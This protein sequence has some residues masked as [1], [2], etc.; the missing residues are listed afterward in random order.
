MVLHPPAGVKARLIAGDVAALLA[1]VAL[2]VLLV[3]VRP[4]E[5]VRPFVLIGLGLMV[6]AIIDASFIGG[7]RPM[8]GGDDGLFYT[9]VGRQILQH[10]I[11]GDIMAALAGGENVYYYGGPGLRYWRALE[12]IV[13]GDTN[14]GYLS[15]VLVLPMIVLG[16]YRRFLSDEF[17]WRLALVFVAI[18][19]GEIFGTSFLDYAKWAARGFADPAAHILLLWGVL[20]IV[21]PRGGAVNRAGIAA[22]GAL[23]LAL[24]VFTKPIVA[25]IPG[26][27]LAGAGLAALHQ[28]QWRRLAGMC[29]GFLPVLVM[30]LHNWYF[31][32]AFVLLSGNACLPG[33]CVMTPTA[34]SSA[35]AELARLDF[36]GPNV[37]QASSQIVSW[38]SQPSERAVSIPFNAVA[39]VIVFYVT[40]RGRDFDPWLRLIGAAVLA[41]FVVDFIYAPTPRYYFEMWLLSAVIVAVFIEHR[42]PAWM[43]KHGWIGAKRVLE[44]SIGYRP[45]QVT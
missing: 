34:I 3:R 13:F 39:A 35:L 28:R 31:G 17:A 19:V 5:T 21:A 25:P 8:D 20:V 27:V 42:L 4:A 26:I 12:M 38:L 30:P 1:V 40:L 33:T 11:H 16:L 7:W 44:R 22:G 23:L 24:A 41:E 18:P 2:L 37:Q 36:G 14:L 10:L 43:D 45:A 15:L 9:G 32:H 29:I 6:I